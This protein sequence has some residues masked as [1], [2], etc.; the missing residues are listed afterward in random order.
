MPLSVIIITKNEASNIG[1]CIAS[2]SFADEIVI[3]DSGST[4]ETVLI[5]QKL[6][7]KIFETDWKGFGHQ[8]NRA[9]D[10]STSDWIFSL[11]AD[12][13]ITS[14]LKKEIQSAIAQAKFN[15]FDVPRSS[16][17]ISKF[18]KHSGWHPDRTIRL[19]KRDSARFSSHQVHEHI[20]TKQK[21]GHLTTPLT[22]YSYRNYETLLNKM[23]TYS[24]AGALDLHDRNKKSSLSSAILHGTWAFIR[25]YFIKLGFLDGSAGF[26]LAFANAETT[27]YKYLKLYLSQLQKK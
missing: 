15:V 22:H 11:D 7:A 20:E 12:E 6:G 4:D 24:T 25:T 21:L 23:N 19:F 2:A 10:F 16:L 17:F 8:K 27:Y 9:I 26:V 18:M 5:A 13:R 3:V 14:E 1:E